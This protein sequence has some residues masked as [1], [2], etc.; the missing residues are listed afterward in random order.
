MHHHAMVEGEQR[1]E[2]LVSKCL[3]VESVNWS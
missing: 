1:I 3:F 2:V